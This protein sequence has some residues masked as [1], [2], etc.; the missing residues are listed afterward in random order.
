LK[1]RRKR[2]DDVRFGEKRRKT[3]EKNWMNGEL[4]KGRGGMRWW[5]KSRWRE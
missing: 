2:R 5:Y 4:E 1:K 3:G